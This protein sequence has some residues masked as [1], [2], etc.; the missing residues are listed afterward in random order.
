MDRKMIAMKARQIESKEQLLNFLNQIRKDEM[1]E[2][3]MGKACYP[4]TI[5]HL[6]FYCN[7]NNSFHRYKHFNIKKKSGGT[8]QIT[9]P[10][11]KSFMLILR[12][13]NEL[14]K[15]LYTPSDYVMGFT[16]RRSV[17][18]NAS[19]HKG[20]NYIFNI[21]LKDFFPSIEQARVWKRLQLEPICLKKP[22]ASI[23]AGLC[24]MKI[25]DDGSTAKYVLP[26]GAPTS[27]ILSNM[28]CDKLDRRLAGL[29]KRFGL[30]Y[31]RYADDITFS[32]MHNV[33]QTNGVFRTELTRIIE[34][35]GFTMNNNKTRL[36]KVGSRQEV[37]GII[38]SEKINVT[39]NYVRDIRNIL[40][41]WDRYGFDTAYNKFF[42]KYKAEKGHVKKGE[43]DL[44]NVLDGKLMYLK[45]VKGEN[46]SVYLCLKQKFDSLAKQLCNGNNTN[47]RG[48]TFV[49]TMPVLEFESR[50]NTTITIT[51]SKPKD[52]SPQEV[53]DTLHADEA[54]MAKTF[55]PHRYAF[56]TLGERKQKASVNKSLT[57]EEETK[58]ELLS[59]SRCRNAKG[60]MFWLIHRTDKVMVP[61]TSPVD[62]EELNQELDN[63]LN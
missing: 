15:S 37:T 44:V 35:Q 23:I 60:T 51:T 48:V 33:Y 47:D 26:Q 40:Y 1:T 50:N 59:I 16:E 17:V 13:V 20:Q 11:N 29:A 36:Q 3:S 7:P 27:P 62:I 31:S 43:P 55:V 9:A 32:S 42:P 18:T 34:D 28:I 22:I 63:L 14:L 49:K 2:D 10:R 54:Q 61:P 19:I 57:S 45:M 8:R 39:Q 30:H 52:S 58:K 4:F 41:I 24:S 38:V 56:F 21:D 6:N 53:S 46:D 25:K 5:K 12:H